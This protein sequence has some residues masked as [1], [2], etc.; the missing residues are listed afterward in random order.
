M[1]LPISFRVPVVRHADVA[2]PLAAQFGQ[3]E[4]LHFGRGIRGR[5]EIEYVLADGVLYEVV[6]DRRGDVT[7]EVVPDGVLRDEILG[8]L[9]E[10]TAISDCTPGFVVNTP[11]GYEPEVA[12]QRYWL[13]KP[14]PV[15][16][17]RGRTTID[18]NIVSVDATPDDEQ[19]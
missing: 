3:S 8:D 10:W 12:P 17:L 19:N 5:N 18:G 6:F 1:K 14:Q 16:E 7:L 9:T 11:D 4:G 2:R 15:L 13:G